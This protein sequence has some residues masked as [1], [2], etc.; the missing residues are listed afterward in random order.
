MTMSL[1]DAQKKAAEGCLDG[2][3]FA[4]ALCIMMKKP[5]TK[6]NIKKVTGV[7]L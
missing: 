4:Y 2:D 1:A 5:V 7:H 3:N 6:E